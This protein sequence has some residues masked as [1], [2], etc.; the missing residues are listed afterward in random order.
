M[1]LLHLSSNPPQQRELSRR[2]AERHQ[3][4]VA[5]AELRASRR[6]ASP[7]LSRVRHSLATAL[8]A[9]ARLIDAT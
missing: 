6:A 9:T 3:L 2:A 4:D 1:D 8:V 7:P 5:V